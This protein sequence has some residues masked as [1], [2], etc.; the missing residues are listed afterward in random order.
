[1]DP[2]ERRLCNSHGENLLK[3]G[4]IKEARTPFYFVNRF[5]VVKNSHKKQRPFL[6]LRHTIFLIY[7]VKIKFDHCRTTKDFVDNECFSL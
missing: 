1:M 7:K 5:T 4:R 3:Y 2:S 6:D